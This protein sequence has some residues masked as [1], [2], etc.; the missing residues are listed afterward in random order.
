MIKVRETVSN[1]FL[2]IGWRLSRFSGNT[3]MGKLIQNCSF[4]L[5]KTVHFQSMLWLFTTLP[6]QKKQNIK[7]ALN[8]KYLQIDSNEQIKGDSGNFEGKRKKYPRIL[9]VVFLLSLL[10]CFRGD[11]LGEEYSW[12]R[13]L[14]HESLANSRYQGMVIVVKN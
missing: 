12:L 8:R 4:G 2:T 6:W 1:M 9:C 7:S 5:H 11:H 14:P 13:K 3:F 10:N